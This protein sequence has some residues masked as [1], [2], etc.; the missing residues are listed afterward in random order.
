MLIHRFSHRRN[1]NLPSWPWWHVIQNAHYSSASEVQN[2]SWSDIWESL[3][4]L[5]LHWNP[6]VHI[7]TTCVG[8]RPTKVASISVS[9]AG[10][11]CILHCKKLCKKHNSTAQVSLGSWVMEC[12]L[13]RVDSCKWIRTAKQNGKLGGWVGNC[14]E[15]SAEEKKKKKKKLCMCIRGGGGG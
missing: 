11:W 14:G 4:F 15:A 12:N 8:C 3:Y 5:T 13:S 10:I 2:Q 6:D 7:T 1:N 9:N